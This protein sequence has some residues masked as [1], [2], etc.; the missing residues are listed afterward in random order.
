[1][2]G[3]IPDYLESVD[4]DS[5]SFPASWFDA[6]IRELR[7]DQYFVHCQICG[8]PFKSLAQVLTL[9]ADHKTPRCRGGKTTWV[10]LQI[11]CGPCNL[12][13]RDSI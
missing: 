8:K 10:N 2:K 3:P 7:D 9:Q 12:R 1:M 5:S 13:K 4:P 6:A 11:L